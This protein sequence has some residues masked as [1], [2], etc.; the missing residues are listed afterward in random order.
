MSRVDREWRT[1]HLS[2]HVKRKDGNH[3]EIVKELRGV[4]AFVVDMSSLGDGCPD[5]LAAFGGQ[6]HVIEIKNP[7]TAYGRAGLSA[8]QQAA[9]TM[10]GSAPVHVVSSVA[11]ALKAI[12]AY[13]E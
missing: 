2:R 1:S 5:I 11:E 9:A 10:A 8:S 4:G 13:S 7:A 6:W 3:A 12:G